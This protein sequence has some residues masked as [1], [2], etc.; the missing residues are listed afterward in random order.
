MVFFKY[1]VRFKR[2]G[3]IQK[4]I[5]SSSI[6]SAFHSL[7]GS[8][9]VDSEADYNFVDLEFNSVDSA[10]NHATTGFKFRRFRIRFRVQFNHAMIDSSSVIWAFNS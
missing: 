9:F 2:R 5:D 4:T 3:S 6:D 10:F 7:T 1:G 8:N